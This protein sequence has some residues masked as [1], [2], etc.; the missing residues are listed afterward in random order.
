MVCRHLAEKM[1]LVY[2]L[3]SPSIVGVYIPLTCKCKTFGYC[4]VMNQ[5]GM[6]ARSEFAKGTETPFLCSTGRNAT[7]HKCMLCKNRALFGRIIR[8]TCQT[9]KLCSLA[10]PRSTDANVFQN[11]YQTRLQ[12]VYL[13][14]SAYPFSA[15]RAVRA[16]LGCLSDITGAKPLNVVIYALFADSI[17]LIFMFAFF[18]VPRR[19]NTELAIGE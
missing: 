3:N 17:A 18:W 2:C 1:S 5:S 14:C 4:R 10:T 11:G 9:V 16:V 12:H 13:D 8:I 15:V 6:E 19:S 7:I